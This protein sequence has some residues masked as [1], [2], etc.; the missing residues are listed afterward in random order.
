VEVRFSTPVQVNP[1]A[2]I[3]SYTVG[4]SSF[5]G[6]KQLGLGVNHSSPSS[7]EVKGRIKLYCYTSS[8]LFHGRL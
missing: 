7:A 4:T 6:V 5:L 8:L 3:A 2:H 1:G